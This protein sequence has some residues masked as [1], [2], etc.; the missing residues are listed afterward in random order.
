MPGA[1]VRLGEGGGELVVDGVGLVGAEA[2]GVDAED[3]GELLLEPVAGG[4]AGEEV[5]VR[6]EDT[7]GLPGAR[8]LGA[9]DAQLVQR[10]ARGV[11]DAAQVV[12][13]AD[14]QGRRVREGG[15]VDE[16]LRVEVA[17]RG[18]DGQLLDVVE[19]PA[20]DLPDTRVGRQQPVGVVCVG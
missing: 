4:G 12:V 19:Q 3:V 18:D 17:V 11:Q 15:V 16:H 2:V 1:E 7:P 14:D 6:G 8:A 5:P 13:G 10:H 9:A 20:C